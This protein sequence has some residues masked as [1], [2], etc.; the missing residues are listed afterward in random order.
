MAEA[1]IEVGLEEALTDADIGAMLAECT[2][3]ET[4]ITRLAERIGVPATNQLLIQR[5]TTMWRE[6]PLAPMGV[7]VQDFST[8][9]APRMVDAY[10]TRIQSEATPYGSYTH[11]DAAEIFARWNQ[12]RIRRCKQTGQWLVWDGRVWKDG[13]LDVVLDALDHFLSIYGQSGLLELGGKAGAAI[14][15]QINAQGFMHGTMAFLENKQEL[16]VD[17]GEL[18]ADPWALNTPDGIIDLRTGA[19]TAHQPEAYCTKITACAPCSVE[20]FEAQFTGSRF[21]QFLHEIFERVPREEVAE[22]IAFEQQT[23]GYCLTGDSTL[24]FLKFWYGEGRNGK[25]TLGELLQGVAGTYSKKISNTVLM[26]AKG[27]RHP[28]EIA[29]LLGVRMAVASEI[30]EGAYINEA[31]V[32]ELTGD[33]ELSARFMRKD[34]FSFARTHKHIIYGNNKPRLRIADAA[35][36]SR[37]KLTAFE[38]NF[39][40]AGRTDSGLKARLM[41]ESGLILRWLL[42]GARELYQGGMRMPR[43]AFVS[44]ETE[45][46]VTDNDVLKLWLDERTVSGVAGVSGE[47]VRT[48][49]SELYRDYREW[50]MSRGEHS[51]SIQRWAQLMVTRGQKRAVR[52][53]IA[54]FIGIG[55]RSDRD[56]F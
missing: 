42:E 46:Y 38:V 21:N 43:S 27:E 36:K 16:A 37:L 50:R 32:K 40:A 25:S 8:F 5:V 44:R 29:N 24:H 9:N 10:I 30:A 19:L 11:A 56:Q 35:I 49:S 20:E 22:L 1:Q 17:V 26:T 41:E 45:D 55:L 23:C 13:A 18:D 6:R 48:R 31:L 15:K 47:A 14:Q 52:D 34:F 3:L 7:A 53:G 51:E 4:A 33:A 39:E 54:V 28:T 2:E 12:T